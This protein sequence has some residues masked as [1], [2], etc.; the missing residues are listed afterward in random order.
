MT[1]AVLADD[2]TSAA[3]LGGVGFRW[4]LVSEVAVEM[5][6]EEASDLVVIN[7]NTRCLPPDHA[8]S[9]VEDAARRLWRSHHAW[10]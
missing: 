9:A 7:T 5:A 8:R 1:V 3:E 6:S 2:L 10:M 4:G